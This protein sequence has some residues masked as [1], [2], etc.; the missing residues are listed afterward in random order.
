MKMMTA[1]MRPDGNDPSTTTTG[2][3]NMKRMR[4]AIAIR[5]LERVI[6]A[7]ATLS[8]ADATDD[9]TGWLGAPGDCVDAGAAG[10]GLG[11]DPSLPAAAGAVIVVDAFWSFLFADF[12]PLMASGE[13]ARAI[14][15]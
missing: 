10:P 14:D 9:A 7:G 4:T 5:T 11:A 15:V 1:L 13:Y 2:S 12:N 3:A 8:G 6:F